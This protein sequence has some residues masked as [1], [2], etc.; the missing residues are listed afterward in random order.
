MNF[1]VVTIVY[2]NQNQ[3]TGTVEKNPFKHLKVKW[4]AVIGADKKHSAKKK[5]QAF[6]LI[7]AFSSELLDDCFLFRLQI[8][9]VMSK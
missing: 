9:Y 7:R 1:A 4:L 5:F 2:L 8:K 6:P 3:R